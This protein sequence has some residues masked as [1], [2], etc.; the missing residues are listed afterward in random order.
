M[1]VVVLFDQSF[2]VSTRASFSG[3]TGARGLVS[4]SDAADAGSA[5]SLSTGSNTHRQL[6]V[7]DLGPERVLDLDPPS[8]A[9]ESSDE[10]SDDEALSL[11]RTPAGLGSLAAGLSEPGASLAALSEPG[12]SLEE[13]EGADG[14]TSPNPPH[15]PDVDFV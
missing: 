12:A 5:R 9:P 6:E 2:V 1:H 4:L 15:S 7:F 14:T 13:G 3:G 8:P 10:D 11:T